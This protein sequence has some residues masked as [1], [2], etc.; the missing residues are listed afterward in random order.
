LQDGGA[1]FWYE[2]PASGVYCDFSYNRIDDDEDATNCSASGLSFNLNYIRPSFFAYE[3]MPLVQTFCEHFNLV[4]EDVQE[5]TVGK[6]NADNLIESW[7]AHNSRA[8]RALSGESDARIQYLPEVTAS[9]WWRY[10][11]FKSELEA[12]VGEDI[13]VPSI[14]ILQGPQR[15]RLFTITVWPDGIPQFFPT[16]DYLLIERTKER[17]F[18]LKKTEEI[19]LVDYEVAMSAIGLLLE[20]YEGPGGTIKYLKPGRSKEASSAVQAFDLLPIELSQ[21]T[22]VSPDDFVDVEPT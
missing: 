15:P 22:R 13:F 8:V 7:R 14:L 9:N 3:T 2:N 21:H 12:S 19:G 5:E 17:L 11:R 10:S 20:E 6:P 4:V 1:Q 18:G 16:C